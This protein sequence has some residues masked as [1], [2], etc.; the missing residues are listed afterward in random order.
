[1]NEDKS[2]GLDLTPVE[3]SS[4]VVLPHGVG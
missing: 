4:V 1:V 2:R 3:S